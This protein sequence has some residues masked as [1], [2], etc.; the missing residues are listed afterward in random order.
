MIN[1]IEYDIGGLNTFEYDGVERELFES[2]YH[3]RK[4]VRTYAQSGSVWMAEEDGKVIAVG[5]FYHLWKGVVQAWVYLNQKAQENI[6]PF[7]RT[8]KGKIDNMLHEVHRIQTI[9]LADSEEANNL[10]KHLGFQKE[11]TLRQ[12]TNKRTDM[13]MYSI[14]KGE[15]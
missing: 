2:A 10:L 6:L 7:Y 11:G 12:F 3:V 1:I 5:G 13:V 8:M 14:V 9:C 15:Q 4:L